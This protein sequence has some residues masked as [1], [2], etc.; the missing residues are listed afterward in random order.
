M[1]VSKVQRHWENRDIL[2]AGG[3]L[4]TSLKASNLDL[5]LQIHHVFWLDLPQ[6]NLE[7][8]CSSF[9]YLN[10]M[11]NF[12]FFSPLDRLQSWSLSRDHDTQT[13]IPLASHL[14]VFYVKNEC[15]ETPPKS[16]VD[17]L[18]AHALQLQTDIYHW[19]DFEKQ[20]KLA[21]QH[22]LPP[23]AVQNSV[24]KGPPYKTTGS[25]QV[26][27]YMC[28]S[29]RISSFVISLPIAMRLCC[30]FPWQPDD[31]DLQKLGQWTWPHCSLPGS[32]SADQRGA[33]NSDI[34]HR[35]C[36]QSWVMM[37]MMVSLLQEWKQLCSQKLWRFFLLSHRFLYFPWMPCFLLPVTTD[38]QTCSTWMS[39][40]SQWQKKKKNLQ[41]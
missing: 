8:F 5:L 12:I 1:H 17:T 36:R 39:K 32:A 14:Q 16:K 13:A 11:K 7:I 28:S 20:N 38:W 6:P 9:E 4:A 15:I 34:P 41:H 29:R 37:P 19:L 35:S 2:S 21:N 40:R 27:T 25:S 33:W 31:L 3:H 10:F 24:R 18:H 22:I 23:S 26:T 30:S